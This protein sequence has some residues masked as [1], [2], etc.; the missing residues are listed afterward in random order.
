MTERRFT[1]S[2][3][4]DLSSYCLRQT[5]I[6]PRFSFRS[7][8]PD[9]DVITLSLRQYPWTRFLLCHSKTFLDDVAFLLTLSSLDHSCH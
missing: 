1:F 4:G 5:P 3:I 6:R 7:S 2:N 9:R 8:L